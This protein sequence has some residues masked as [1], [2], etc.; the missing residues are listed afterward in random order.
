MQRI[1]RELAQELRR[2]FP[3]RVIIFSA[4]IGT[5][6]RQA[7]EASGCLCY[8]DPARAIRVLAAMRFFAK[9]VET[10]LALENPKRTTACLDRD[11]Y[12]EAQAMAL[13]AD[14][15]ISTLPY[16]QVHARE[17]AAAGARELGFPVVMKV[18]SADIVH[19]SQL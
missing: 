7:L 5:E 14:I 11:F 8:A 16:C 15:G 4:L 10:P 2:D 18:L 6:Q 17:E 1:Q 12:N 9:P 13:L 3:D 19:K